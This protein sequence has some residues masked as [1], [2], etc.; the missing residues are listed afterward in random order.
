MPLGLTAITTMRLSGVDTTGCLIPVLMLMLM[1]AGVGVRAAVGKKRKGNDPG[2]GL[3]RSGK[4]CRAQHFRSHEPVVE[5]HL[6]TADDSDADV[7]WSN[8]VEE[9]IKCDEVVLVGKRQCEQEP[10]RADHSKRPRKPG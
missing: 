2:R 9:A 10:R 7:L 4:L 5:H 8:G 3:G 6:A 1:T